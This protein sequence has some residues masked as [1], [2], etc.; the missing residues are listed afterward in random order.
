[1]DISYG[2]LRTIT[3][4]R[5]RLNILRSLESPMRLSDLRRAV[6]SNAPNTSSKAKDLQEL[7]LITR[8]NGDY[9]ITHMGKLVSQRVSVLLDTLTTLYTHINFWSG[10]IDKL[11]DDLL[12]SIH[13]FKGARLVV[14]NRTNLDRVRG[15]II[16]GINRAEGE[17]L[18]IMPAHSEGILKAVE[19]AS[20]RVKTVLISL[21]DRPELHYGLVSADNFRILFTEMVDMA[22]VKETVD[23]CT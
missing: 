18:V 17:L 22:L 20:Q 7:S 6:N 5:L 19:K 12:D 1:M 4:S 9:Q 21:D 10:I 8:D 16:R 14:N 11:P 3:S 23:E 2:I 15:E 13:E